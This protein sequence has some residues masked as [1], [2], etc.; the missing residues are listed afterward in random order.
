MPSVTTVS[1]SPGW[2]LETGVHGR[3]TSSVYFSTMVDPFF[4]QTMRQQQRIRGKQ[5]TGGVKAKARP[6]IIHSVLSGP[7]PNPQ[8]AW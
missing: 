2:N 1:F 5:L 4:S 3:K 8:A 6:R 7:E